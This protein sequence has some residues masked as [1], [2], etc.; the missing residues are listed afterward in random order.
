MDLL[1]PW[2]LVDYL[3]GSKAIFFAIF[4]KLLFSERW[5]LLFEYQINIYTYEVIVCLGVVGLS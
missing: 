3:R 4:D 1:V 2:L 5:T